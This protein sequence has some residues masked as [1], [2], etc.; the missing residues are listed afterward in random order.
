MPHLTCHPPPTLSPSTLPPLPD[1][2][3]TRTSGVIPDQ[4]LA[5]FQCTQCG[6]E[7]MSWNDR[8]KVNEPAK[9]GNPACQVRAVDVGVDVG[10]SCHA[11]WNSM[12]PLAGVCRSS[13]SPT[14]SLIALLTHPPFHPPLRRP[15]SRCRWCTTAPCSWTSS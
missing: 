11:F 12:L 4:S 9:C 10:L 1:P 13:S 5:L 14:H 2:Q 15:S 8:G 6:H 7:E 3:V